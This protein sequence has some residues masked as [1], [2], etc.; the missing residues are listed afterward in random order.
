[1][2]KPFTIGIHCVVEKDRKIL[3]TKRSEYKEVH[4][5]YWDLT[6]G[7]LNDGEQPFEC[8]IRE[9]KEETGL[10][11]KP[12]EVLTAYSFDYKEYW[13]TVILIRAKHID[14]E[15]KLSGEHTEY[16]WI[17]SSEL[18]NLTPRRQMIDEYLKLTNI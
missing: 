10:T 15:V 3:V 6:G 1:M 16:K 4:A 2:T 5:G 18:K 7:Q 13:G 11:V 12:I 9:V 8:A 14:G 17:E